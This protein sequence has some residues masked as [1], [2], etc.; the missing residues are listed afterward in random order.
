M[1][2]RLIASKVVLFWLGYEPEKGFFLLTDNVFISEMS[3][4]ELGNPIKNK[5]RKKDYPQ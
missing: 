1:C 3:L 4:K 5:Y 2:I